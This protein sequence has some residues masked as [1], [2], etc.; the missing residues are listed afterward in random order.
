M[1]YPDDD[2]IVQ[3]ISLRKR[4]PA[5]EEGQGA[6]SRRARAAVDNGRYEQ[7][8][9]GPQDLAESRQPVYAVGPSAVASTAA[10]TAQT[11]ELLDS[12][13]RIADMFNEVVGVRPW[14]AP[15]GLGTARA[16]ASGGSRGLGPR[17]PP[18]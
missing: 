2:Q 7:S 16:R 18:G 3:E 5:E 4:G 12:M 17:Q 15:S 6:E 14:E 11:A 13:Q 9:A 1:Y 8:R 10:S